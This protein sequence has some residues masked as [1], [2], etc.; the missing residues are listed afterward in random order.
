MQKLYEPKDISTQFT[1]TLQVENAKKNS[2]T[3]FNVCHSRGFYNSLDNKLTESVNGT[4]MMVYHIATMAS[5]WKL[6]P[7]TEAYS[8][9]LVH[10]FF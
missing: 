10:A 1:K 3:G 2:L 8:F 9:T 6:R 5:S 7:K 4:Q